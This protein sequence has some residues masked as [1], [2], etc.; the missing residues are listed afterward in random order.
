MKKFTCLLVALLAVHAVRSACPTTASDYN[1]LASILI[2]ATTPA[3]P[4]AF[5][6]AD[7]L[8]TAVATTGYCGTNTLCITAAATPKVAAWLDNRLKK[9]A[10]AFGAFATGFV[11]I[12]KRLTKVTGL[13]TGIDATV[14]SGVTTSTIGGFTGAQVSPFM[15]K[16]ADAAAA[17]TA[18]T[19]FKDGAVGCYNIINALYQTAL[20]DGISDATA[21]NWFT[22]GTPHLTQIAI[23]TASAAAINTACAKV[24]GFML[25]SSMLALGGAFYTKTKT[26]AGGTFTVPTALTFDT[27]ASVAAADIIAWDACAADPAATACTNTIYESF[28]KG[29]LMPFGDNPLAFTSVVGTAAS[30]AFEGTSATAA[31]GAARRQ[32]AAATA[33][34]LAL[35]IGTTNALVVSA[36][37]STTQIAAAA[38][39]T[40]VFTTATTGA[41]SSGYVAPSTTGSGS[42]SGSSSTTKSNANVLIGSILSFL[43]IALLN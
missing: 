26:G 34:T 8:G 19:A 16:W 12:G 33:N 18:W 28:V 35:T 3:L 24:W 41:W 42:S 40:A 23:T 9:V 32:L 30:S 5:A 27:K 36:T 11:N 14:F 7:F 37:T 20:C 17:Q 43:A 4:S 25:R 13:Q 10:D 6:A 38:T 31:F 2:T 39:V 15:T 29:M 22:G 21:A 1:S